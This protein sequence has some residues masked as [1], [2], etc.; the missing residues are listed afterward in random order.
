MCCVSEWKKAVR[1]ADGT[2]VRVRCM[3]GRKREF[4]YVEQIEQ[5]V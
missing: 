1:R 3:S 4:E 2:G 5:R